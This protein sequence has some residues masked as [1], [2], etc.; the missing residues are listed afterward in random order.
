M[1]TT[2][3]KRKKRVVRPH[4]KKEVLPPLS[5]NLLTL[6]APFNTGDPII[7]HGGPTEKGLL[8]PPYDVTAEYIPEEHSINVKVTVGINQELDIEWL[9]IYGGVNMTKDNK[10]ENMQRL[11][12]VY[13]KS[14]GVMEEFVPYY[15]EFK[16]PMILDEKMIHALEF[17]LWNEDPKTSRGTVTTVKHSKFTMEN[18][19]C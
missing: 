10:G 6:H 17:Y 12:I 19:K 3:L 16:V 5:S 13:D 14:E 7:Y 1:N 18:S 15:L 11:Y 8:L 4:E 2:D 9:D